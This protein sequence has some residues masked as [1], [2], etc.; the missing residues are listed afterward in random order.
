MIDF[1]LEIDLKNASVCFSFCLVIRITTYLINGLNSSDLGNVVILIFRF[2][3]DLIVDKFEFALRI[4]VVLPTL[5]LF[6]EV[7]SENSVNN[8][9]R[10]SFTVIEE[11]LNL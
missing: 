8:T 2:L 5:D 6:S 7:S 10:S 1:L 11:N 3:R 4:R 9:Q